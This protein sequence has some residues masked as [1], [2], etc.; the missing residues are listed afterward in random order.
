MSVFALKPSPFNPAALEAIAV[1]FAVDVPY[2]ALLVIPADASVRRAVFDL[3]TLG[4]NAHNLDVAEATKGGGYLLRKDVQPDAEPTLLVS[5]LATVRGLDLPE[6]SHVFLLGIPRALTA[7]AYLHVAG[8]VGR[9]GKGGKV[10]AVVEERREIETAE[11]KTG[12]KDE[13]AWLKKIYERVGV[14]PTKFEHFED[15]A[16]HAET[17][18]RD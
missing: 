13:P 4:V 7:D 11:G 16:E 15:A 18:G 5:T 12:Y 6:L 9:F 3:R 14:R 17:N 1:A 8:R 10:V 2:V